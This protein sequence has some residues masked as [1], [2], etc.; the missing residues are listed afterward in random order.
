[1]ASR[2]RHAAPAAAGRRDPVDKLVP[3][4]V[5]RKHQETALQVKVGRLSE[6]ETASNVPD[7]PSRRQRPQLPR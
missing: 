2:R 5:W 6:T 1:M 7:N 3:V 4:K